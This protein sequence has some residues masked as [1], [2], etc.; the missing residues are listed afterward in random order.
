M[1][2]VRSIASSHDSDSLI[3][4][5]TNAFTRLHFGHLLCNLHGDGVEHPGKTLLLG[6]IWRR[7]VVH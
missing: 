4:L 6:G 3:R 5:V 7:H 1:M 2:L